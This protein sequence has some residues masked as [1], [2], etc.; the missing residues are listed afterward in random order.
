MFKTDKK[1]RLFGEESFDKLQRT[2]VQDLADHIADISDATILGKAGNIDQFI[3][4]LVNQFS[5]PTVEISFEKNGLVV[6]P[7]IG[8]IEYYGRRL[9]R[10]YIKYTFP[11]VR[12]RDMLR[13]SPY[14]HRVNTFWVEDLNGRLVVI[15]DTE[16]ASLD[17]P[18]DR[19][20]GFNDFVLHF[21]D[22]V[23][24][25]AGVLNDVVG[26]FNDGLNEFITPRVKERLAVAQRNEKN[27]DDLNP[28]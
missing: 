18:E 28:F 23:K 8:E 21:R 9:P 24:E 7:Y 27:K 19:K 25:M 11:I 5:L 2:R 15:Y 1:F 17:F 20:K 12:G 6:N 10:A 3:A 13:Y 26:K 14:N 22:R 16:Y 4:E